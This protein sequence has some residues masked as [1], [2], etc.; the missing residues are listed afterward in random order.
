MSCSSLKKYKII[1][2]SSGNTSKNLMFSLGR[3]PIAQSPIISTDTMPKLP[4][5]LGP[6]AI[7][8]SGIGL[9]IP[10]TWE[11]SRS[12][13]GGFP[14]LLSALPNRQCTP[15]QLLKCRST[16]RTWHLRV[17]KAAEKFD[18]RA[19]VGQNCGQL[20]QSGQ[21]PQLSVWYFIFCQICHI[22]SKFD[23]LQR[24][25]HLFTKCCWL[26][27]AQM[28]TKMPRY[29]IQNEKIEYKVE[30]SQKFSASSSATFLC[31]KTLCKYFVQVL[32]QVC[33][34][35]L[36]TFQKWF[37]S[38]WILNRRRCGFFALKLIIFK[39][40]LRHMAIGQPLAPI[41]RFFCNSQF[42]S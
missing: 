34:N 7:S 9:K 42:F 16:S 32:P 25:I 30:N 14:N 1:F 15:P 2:S 8:L 18:I 31:K 10:C 3:C 6:R 39:F 11:I 36:N 12:P 23:I 27:N 13:G 28:Y 41:V 38:V 35:S 26:T 4:L 22:C 17:K 37:H 5:G 24:N 33:Q 20:S 29:Q 40:F 21:I 19:L